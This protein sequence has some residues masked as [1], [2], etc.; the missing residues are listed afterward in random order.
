MTGSKRGRKIKYDE[1]I[2]PHLS[3]IKEWSAAGATEK[4]ICSALGIALS[5]FYEY[6]KKY[7]ELSIAL[8]EGR[9][10]VILNIKAALYK[11]AVGFE[12]EEK[13]GIQKD[14]QTTN[15]EIYKRYA[16]PD[17]EAAKM[18]LRNYDNE[19]RDKDT[20]T[21]DFKRQEIELRKALAAANNFDLDIE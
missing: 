16:Q 4:E 7:S 14:G 1:Y 18:L 15:I 11:K 19:W 12:Y 10:N 2:K 13:K 3:K 20:I 5:T 17:T 9:Q 21:N 8:R 6:K